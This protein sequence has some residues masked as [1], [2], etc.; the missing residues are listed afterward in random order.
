MS[1]EY[2]RLRKPLSIVFSFWKKSLDIVGVMLAE[3]KFAYLRVDGTLPFGQRKRILAQFQAAEQGMVLLM[4][5]G[6]GAIG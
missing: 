2:R 4:T 1:S 6:T 3:K 5:L